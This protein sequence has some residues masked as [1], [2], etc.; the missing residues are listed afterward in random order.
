MIW[1]LLGNNCQFL[2]LDVKTK[3][4]EKITNPKGVF[5]T[6]KA[7]PDGNKIVF[8]GHPSKNYSSVATDIYVRDIVRK[9]KL[10]TKNSAP[11]QK[12]YFG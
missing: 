10:L 12:I 1:E 6:P 9:N 2:S 5:S 7:S 4:L 8:T 11:L 3:K